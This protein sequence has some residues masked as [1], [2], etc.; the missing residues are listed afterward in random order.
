MKHYISHFQAEN[1]FSGAVDFNLVRK[2]EKVSQ[3]VTALKLK[4]S[5]N[6]PFLVYTKKFWHRIGNWG[7]PITSEKSLHL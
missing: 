4:Y 2:F 3:S 1:Q 7:P 6:L 5:F